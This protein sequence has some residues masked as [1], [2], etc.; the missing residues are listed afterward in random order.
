MRQPTLHPACPTQ[1]VA[2]SALV[3][4]PRPPQTRRGTERR[5][6]LLSAANQLFLQRG[7]AQVSLDDL[8]AEVGGSKAAIYQYFG[9]K[10]G[11]LAAL[12]SY[13][14]ELFFDENEPPEHLDNQC[15]RV[16]L[17]KTAQLIYQ[18]FTRPDNI[19][20]MRLIIEAS[21]N[22]REMA[23]LAYDAGPRRGLEKIATLL[24]EAHDAGQIDCPEPHESAILFLGILRHAQWRL[25][26]GLPAFEPD[27]YD[28][29]LIPKLID[30]FLAAHRRV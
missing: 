27:L 23:E 30:R 29:Q 8:V 28:D 4:Q 5:A 16:Q 22:D 6:A 26:V 10:K 25:L 14:C 7:F 1:S 24:H 9:S 15:I 3:A 21:Q 13:R 17:L 2:T 18:A 19:A 11:L 20:F 12:V